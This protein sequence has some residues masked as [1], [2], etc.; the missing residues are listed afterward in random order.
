MFL[1]CQIDFKGKFEEASRPDDFTVSQTFLVKLQT[2][3]QL[4]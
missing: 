3:F 1:L 4:S 2:L